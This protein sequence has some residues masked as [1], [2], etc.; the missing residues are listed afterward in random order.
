MNQES[1]KK[2]SYKTVLVHID[3]DKH[4]HERLTLAAAIASH[5]QAHLLGVSRQIHPSRLIYEGGAGNLLDAQWEDE[6]ARA[7]LENFEQIARSAGVPSYETRQMNDEAGSCLS[8]QARYS[9]LVVISQSDHDDSSATTLADFQEFVVVNSGRPVLIVPYA[10]NFKAISRRVLIAWDA[11]ASAARA[12]AA[13]LPILKR[14]D[15]VD[16]IVFNA[17]Q[18][19]GHSSNDISAYLAR[20]DINANVVRHEAATDIGDALLSSAADLGSDLIVMGGFGRSRLREILLGGV[21]STVLQSMTV[22]VL[23]AH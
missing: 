21:T 19:G 3:K 10:G 5:E 8:Q 23:M 12:V 20:H 17:D 15:E 7:A 9:D 2:M 1:I 6:N 11:S 22:P 14:A 4:A 18:H 13:A 16:I